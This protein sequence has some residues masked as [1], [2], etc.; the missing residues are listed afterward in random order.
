MASLVVH[1]RDGQNIR[2]GIL[3]GTA[4]TSADTTIDVRPIQSPAATTADV[5]VAHELRDLKTENSPTVTIP[6]TSLL[7][8]ITND[9]AL[10]CQGLNYADHAAEAQHHVRKQNLWFAKANSAISGAY[11]PIVRPREVQLLDYEVEL[12]S[13]CAS[14]STGRSQ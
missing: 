9:A 8:P 4:P 2:W 1:Y 14:Q 10:I 6:A 11:D 3:V 5:I 12:A 13:C 7:S